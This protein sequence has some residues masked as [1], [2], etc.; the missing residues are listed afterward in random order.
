MSICF[1]AVSSCGLRGEG[2]WLWGVHLVWTCF[3]LASD[4][5]HRGWMK[6]LASSSRQPGPAAPPV[7]DPRY[8]EFVNR[9][10]RQL[11]FEAH[12]VLE[13]LWRLE[14]GCA[15]EL[16]YKGL[17][18]LAGAFVH[19]K[20]GR[21]GPAANLLRL[22]DA[23]LR[24]YPS[25]YQCLNLKTVRHLIRGA[26][27]RLGTLRQPGPWPHLT[28]TGSGSDTPI[29]FAPDAVSYYVERSPVYVRKDRA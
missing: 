22:A 24:R 2:G 1:A 8:A 18:Q 23:N 16:F 9:F 4:R 14:R 6:N 13:D 19:I 27:S 29:C 7:L 21:P 17:I 26:L 11:F 25:T 5:H 28:L 3:D 20:K 12:E 15:N 10:N